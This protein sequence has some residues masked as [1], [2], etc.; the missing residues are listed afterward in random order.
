MSAWFSIIM[1]NMQI[2]IFIN[3]TQVLL[4]QMAIFMSLSTVYLLGIYFHIL[5]FIRKYRYIMYGILMCVIMTDYPS[6]SNPFCIL[7]R[8]AVNS[9][10]FMTA[11]LGISNPIDRQKISLKAMDVVLFGPPKRKST[12]LKGL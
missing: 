3:S 5:H 12:S 2:K 6:Y 8:L 4:Y 1:E 9:A 7:C 11:I 10:Q